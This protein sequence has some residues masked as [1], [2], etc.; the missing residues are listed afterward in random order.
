MKEKKWISI[1]EE[2]QDI[3]AHKS[4]EEVYETLTHPMTEKYLMELKWIRLLRECLRSIFLVHFE[5][6]LIQ[7]Q[8]FQRMC[9]YLLWLNERDCVSSEE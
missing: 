6:L 9:M 7:I 2:K 5:F 4:S 3:I 1:P 8:C